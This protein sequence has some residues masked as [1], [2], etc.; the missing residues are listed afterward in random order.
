LPSLSTSRRTASLELPADFPLRATVLASD[1]DRTLIGEDAVLRERTRDA[2]RAASAAGLHVVVVTGRMFRS[3]RPY[4]LEAGLHDPV[5]CYQGAVVADPVSGEWL[6]HEPIP[7]ELAQETIAVIE[8]EGFPLN[9]YVDDDL[10]VAEI[11]DASRAYAGFQNL[12]ITEVGDLRSW[13]VKP[14]TKLVAVEA[15]EVLDE[16][17]V[18][19]KARF[20]D[21]LFISKSLP[22]FL[23]FASPRVTKGAGLQFLAERL[24]FG[25]EDTVAFGDGENDIELVE[26]GGY[27]VA[28]ANAHPRVLAVADWMCP[29]VDEEGVA[30][31]VEAFLAQR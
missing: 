2:L 9:C 14:P 12:P 22:Y 16:F 20:G 23:E 19:V 24:G 17:E 11:T 21:R 8:A 31:V 1:F 15:P 29:S 7:L 26:W 28:V 4:L 27:G 3:I 25:R 6:R 18:R 13:L 5:V 10:V 30:Q